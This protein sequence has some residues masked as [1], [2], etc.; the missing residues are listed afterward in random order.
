M[1]HSPQHECGVNC[2][3]FIMTMYNKKG[4][5]QQLIRKLKR[6]FLF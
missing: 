5:L 2:T 4:N 3:F 6:S 1:T